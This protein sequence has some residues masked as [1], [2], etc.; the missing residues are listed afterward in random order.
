MTQRLFDDV[1]FWNR[2]QAIT[3]SR[4]ERTLEITACETRHGWV[5]FLPSIT[6]V[7][8]ELSPPLKPLLPPQIQGTVSKSAPACSLTVGRS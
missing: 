2:L 3:Q 6:R 1:P 7:C 8:P 5:H 4:F